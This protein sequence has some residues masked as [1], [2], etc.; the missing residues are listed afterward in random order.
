MIQE[1]SLVAQMVKN[2]P[3]VWE[4]CA[5]S[6]GQKDPLEKGMAT[7]PSILAWRIPWVEGIGG[8]QSVGLQRARHN[9]AT[10]TFAFFLHY[11]KWSYI[12]QEKTNFN[13]LRMF[14]TTKLILNKYF[15]NVSKLNSILSKSVN[16]VDIIILTLIYVCYRAE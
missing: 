8:L 15:R 2:L 6:L 3:A 4:T 5:W 10:N 9:W 14:S 13:G 16:I 7:H 11:T 12:L 1:A